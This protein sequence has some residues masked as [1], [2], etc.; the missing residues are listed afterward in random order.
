MEVKEKKSYD[1]ILIIGLLVV[2][3]LLVVGIGFLLVSEKTLPDISTMFKANGEYTILLDEFLVNLQSER[4]V[5]NY[6]KVKIALMF[7]DEKQGATIDASVNKIRDTIIS[8]LRTKTA[9]DMLNTDKVEKLKED[10]MQDINESLDANI[11]KGVYI[12]DIVVQ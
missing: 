12:T 3:L 6:L 9:S 4:P 2:I 8:N 5:N 10:I 1:K 11:I 7:E